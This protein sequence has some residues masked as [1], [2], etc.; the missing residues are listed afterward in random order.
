[1]GEKMATAVRQG[2]LFARQ[3]INFDQPMLAATYLFSSF[4]YLAFLYLYEIYTKA[5]L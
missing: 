5:T 2:R 1:M 4:R 3:R